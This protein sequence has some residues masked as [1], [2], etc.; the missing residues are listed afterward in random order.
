MPPLSEFPFLLD[1]N[2]KISDRSLRR[3][4]FQSHNSQSELSG[5]A[6]KHSL[7]TV[8]KRNSTIGT[9]VSATLRSSTLSVP[10]PSKKR[11]SGIGAASS[12]GRLF[13]V[14]GDLF[15]LAGRTEDAVV[16]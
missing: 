15:M 10:P 16:W 5:N 1:Q 13:K 12:H 4:S 14:L 3:D 9:P 2:P 6:R 8:L 7:P 11:N